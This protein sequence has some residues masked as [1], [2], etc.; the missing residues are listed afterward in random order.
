MTLYRIRQD[1]VSM[2]P[3]LRPRDTLLGIARQPRT[4]D[5][6]AFDN[7]H[8][9]GTS[10]K[11]LTALTEGQAYVLGDNARDSLDSRHYGPLPA[12]AIRHVI[13]ARLWPWPKII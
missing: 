13:V 1:G 10:I 5:V 11:R 6:V 4:G 3:A 7:P 2:A 8:T 12:T 9:G